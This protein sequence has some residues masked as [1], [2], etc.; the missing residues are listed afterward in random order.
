VRLSVPCGAFR[1]S[2]YLPHARALH[3]CPPPEM[4]VI[5]SVDALVAVAHPCHRDLPDAMTQERLVGRH[6]VVVID[7]ARHHHRRARLADAGAVPLVQLPHP[8]PLACRRQG[9][10]RTTSCSMALTRLRS[11]SRPLSLAFSS[12]SCFSRRS[13]DGPWPGNFYF[14]L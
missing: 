3:R 9:F 13:S 2:R 12:S 8:F 6:G 5:K 1:C 4:A 7:G 14:Q 11:A 10:R